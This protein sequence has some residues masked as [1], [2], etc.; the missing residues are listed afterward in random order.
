LLVAF[1]LTSTKADEREVLLDLLAVEPE[2]VAARPKRP[3]P[4][5]L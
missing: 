5:S 4:W 1:A 3:S 2:P